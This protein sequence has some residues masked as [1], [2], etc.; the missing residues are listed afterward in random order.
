MK[1]QP[2]KKAP[3]KTETANH[4]RRNRI[5]MLA[6]CILFLAGVWAIRVPRSYVNMFLE[7]YEGT[8]AV[9]LEMKG[10]ERST[11]EEEALLPLQQAFDDWKETHLRDE[12]EVTAADGVRLRGGWYDAGSDVTVILFHSFDGSS[13]ESD[14]LFA[15]Y[16][17]EKGY[18][19]LLPDNRNH[20]E[21][22][23]TVTTYGRLEG[24]DTVCWIRWLIERYG[25]EHQVIL[26]GDTL[27][28]SVALSGGAAASRQPDLAGNVAFVVAESPVVNLYDSAGYLLGNQFRLP[29]FMI[30]VCDWFA[31]ESLGESMK[32]VDLNQMTEGCKVPV[33][34]MQGTEDT[35]VDPAAAAEFGGNYGGEVS[36]LTYSS[37]HGMVYAE[38]PDECRAAL[39]QMSDRYL[40]TD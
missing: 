24:G 9:L 19:L 4:Q 32:K 6:L 22:E 40:K 25:K 13:E 3:A 30:P 29:G 26:H 17:A 21:S 39:D 11:E 7:H 35:I 8:S 2:T 16:Y 10:L 27:G 33:L 36:S 28:A 38:H 23:G 34:L 5:L 37:A 20:G 18:N 12:A 1:Q 14:Y 15:P 31:R